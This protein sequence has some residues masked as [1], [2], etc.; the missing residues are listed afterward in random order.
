[1]SKSELTKMAFNGL[2]FKTR[3][4]FED[5]ILQIYLIWESE[6]LN[7]INFGKVIEMIAH[8]GVEKKD[9]NKDRRKI[10]P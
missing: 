9:W 7:T 2:H 8:D 3:D 6:L 4:Y 10:S 1:M 5:W